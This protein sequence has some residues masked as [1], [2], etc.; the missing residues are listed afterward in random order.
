MIKNVTFQNNGLKMA[1]N[2]YLPSDFDEQKQYAAVVCTYPAGA[3]KE[4]I[5]GLYASKLAER[6]FVALAFDATHQGE[7]EGTP[8]YMEI[9]PVF[10]VGT[11]MPSGAICP[12]QTPPAC[13]ALTV[14]H[15]CPDRPAWSA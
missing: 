13:I 3:V 2:L 4:Q 10:R 8:R 1:G 5:S 6:G 14:P 15:P 7:S 11:P 9:P 12:S